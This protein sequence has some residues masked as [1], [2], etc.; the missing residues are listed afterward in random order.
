MIVVIV[1]AMPV[2]GR[3]IVSMHAGPGEIEVAGRLVL[4]LGQHVGAHDA[5]LR[6]V[7]AAMEIGGNIRVA[8]AVVDRRLRIRA[9]GTRTRSALVDDL[10]RRDAVLDPVDQY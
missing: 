9:E 6:E 4:V 3:A 10:P 5:G 2:L 8:R 1:V 7:A